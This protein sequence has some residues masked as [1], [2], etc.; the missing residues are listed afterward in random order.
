MQ[1]RVYFDQTETDPTLIVRQLLWKLANTSFLY[2]I[3][4]HTGV[5]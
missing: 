4:L 3:Y 2:I 1:R 5:V